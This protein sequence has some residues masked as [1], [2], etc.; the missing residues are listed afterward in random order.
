MADP[1]SSQAVIRLTEGQKQMIERLC[2]MDPRG[3]KATTLCRDILMSGV[4]RALLQESKI[5]DLKKKLL[6]LTDAVFGG[7]D[8]R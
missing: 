4:E 8:A 5:L 7:A 3:R 6:E 2:A 1:K